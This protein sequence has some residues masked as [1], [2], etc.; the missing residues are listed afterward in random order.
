MLQTNENNLDDENFPKILV[1]FMANNNII[2]QEYF[3]Q[4]STFKDVI[5]K[6]EETIKEKTIQKPL[7]YTLQNKKVFPNQK[8]IDVIKPNPNKKLLEIE[9]DINSTKI[10]TP[11]T[12]NIPLKFDSILIPKENP[13]RLINY[14]PEN[15]QISTKVYPKE[16]NVQYE[17]FKFN[18]KNSAS[19]NSPKSLYMSGG[20]DNKSDLPSR[21]F[22]KINNQT[23]FPEHSLLPIAKANHSMIFIPDDTIFFVGGNGKETFYFN[24]KEHCFSKWADLN[25]EVQKPFLF[26]NEKD[27]KLYSYNDNDKCLESTDLNSFPIWKETNLYG[28]KKGEKYNCCYLKNNKILFFNKNGESFVY[29]IE[30]KNTVKNKNKF[31]ENIEHDLLDSNCDKNF[32]SNNNFNNVFVPS[33]FEENKNVIVID[34]KNGN[35]VKKEFNLENSQNFNK[36]FLSFKDNKNLIKGD[37]ILRTKE[38]DINKNVNDPDDKNLNE[39]INKIYLDHQNDFNNDSN[40]LKRNK[41]NV[42]LFE[43]KINNVNVYVKEPIIESRE[44]DIRGIIP[45]ETEINIP[46]VKQP[47]V[48]IPSVNANVKINNPDINIKSDF[49]DIKA[50]INDN[51]NLDKLR[52]T[53]TMAPGFNKPNIDANIKAPE[54]NVPTIKPV[55]IKKT[56]VTVNNPQIDANAKVG[57]EEISGIIHGIKKT[58]EINSSEIKKPEVEVKPAKVEVNAPKVEVKP[59]K[60][61]VNAPKVDVPQI[62]AKVDVKPPQINAPKVEVK[63]AKVEVNA[64]KVEVK[65]AKVEVNAPKVEVKPAKV[66]VNAPKVEVKPAK[67]EVNAP[68]VDV[69]QINAKVD[70]KPPKVEVNAPKVDIPQINAPKVEV[71]PAKVEVN[72]P[73]IDIPQINAPKVEVKKAKVEV[74]APNVEVKPAKVDVNAPKVEVKPAKVEVNA[75]KVDV[76]PAKVDVNPPKVEVPQINAKVD[77][78]PAKVEV[79]APKVEVKPEIP[80]VEVKP[81]KVEI[82]PP[83]VEVKPAKVEVNPPKVDIPQINAPKVE[84]K[85]AKVEVNAPKVDVPQINAKVDV[86][87]PQ[88]NA[89]KVEV[90]P[91]KVEVNVPKVEVKPAK[92]DV[93]P[94]KVDVPQINAKVDVKP[95][96]INA[97]KVEVKPAKVEVNVPKVEVKPAKVDVNPPKVDVPQINAKVDVKPPQINAPKVEVKPAK[98]EV[99]APK[100]EVKPAKVDV[101][102]PKVDVPQ[103]NAKVDVKTPKVEVNAPKVEIPKVE[104]P[105][106]KTSNIE[107]NVPI[108]KVD[109][110]KLNIRSNKRSLPGINND[111]IDIKVPNVNGNI[112]INTPNI[113][114]DVN[115]YKANKPSVIKNDIVIDSP[116]VDTN[117]DID[118]NL[119]LQPSKVNYRKPKAKITLD[120]EE[121]YNVNIPKVEILKIEKK[122]ENIQPIKLVESSDIN[123]PKVTLSPKNNEEKMLKAKFDFDGRK[124]V[125]IPKVNITSS[126]VNTEPIYD[127]LNDNNE[128]KFKS[129]AKN[130][131]KLKKPG[132]NIVY[133][134]EDNE[135]FSEEF[136]TIGRP[137]TLTQL[138]TVDVDAKNKIDLDENY[139]HTT[140]WNKNG[141][142]KYNNYKLEDGE[143]E[144]TPEGEANIKLTDYE[145]TKDLLINGNIDLGESTE[146]KPD[147]ITKIKALKSFNISYDKDFNVDD[148]NNQLGG[149]N[150]YEFKYDSEP[151]EVNIEIP[152]DLSQIPNSKYYAAERE[153]LKKIPKKTKKKN[154]LLLPPG[155]SMEAT[156]GL[157]NI[158][159][160]LKE[161]ITEDFKNPF[162]IVEEIKKSD[163]D[164]DK[165]CDYKN[166]K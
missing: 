68:K 38:K 23:F 107:I 7:T 87:P 142:I 121:N 39:I 92:V 155:Q 67:V 108:I 49:G 77:V 62:N 58:F 32:Y 154:K 145:L 2:K 98:V 86:K 10:A 78:K 82:K 17:L 151:A 118:G 148:I 44:E 61:E 103:I 81:A 164:L 94:P 36:N 6:F 63:P 20:V 125:D 16:K 131:M 47:E 13:F 5:E 162:P 80:K 57:G 89:P 25:K 14:S 51:K 117:V 140:K 22:W 119:T 113:E 27:N 120:N 96:Q 95:P 74:N 130:P 40:N 43:P 21:N 9:L 127:K 144:L 166:N 28:L 64:P 88:I 146:K 70:V 42:K 50:S 53:K 90:K 45:G 83:Q 54:I 73:K 31:N 66:D 79:N 157:Y 60:V 106:L 56:E 30:K 4:K 46:N 165:I 100:V 29:D 126:R 160:L 18:E 33:N 41:N 71:K 139:Y 156:I 161:Y 110:P 114:A 158:R 128:M 26:Y 3:P 52:A 69:P 105:K 85:P 59:A 55:E 136:V 1:S 35:L 135:D 134:N 159:K 93:N 149:N 152:S 150:E 112:E 99:N 147:D 101:N 129:K 124:T 123:I 76:K 11:N 34:N 153:K 97:P 122:K 143:S 15:S 163:V 48:N 116:E 115:K 141:G 24:E 8:I 137:F 72:A 111:D 19:C 75:P 84:V 37:I 12:K 132:T 133:T 109:E 104:E 138:M 91:A 65:P 102:P